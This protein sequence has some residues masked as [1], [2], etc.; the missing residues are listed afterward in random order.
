MP[1]AILEAS[2][3]SHQIASRWLWQDLSFSIAAGDRV[4][5]V[6][7]SGAGK[8]V[9]LRT[10]AALEPL[11]QGRICF[12]GRPLSDW[13][14]PHYRARVMYLA[15]RPSLPDSSV[16][17]AI[18][19]PFKLQ[20]HRHKSYNPSVLVNL[21]KD[22]ERDSSFLNQQTPYLSG[23]E[24]QIVT[25]LRALVL[26]PTILLLDEPTASLD[27]RTAGAIETAIATW[28]DSGDNRACLWTSHNPSQLKRVTTRHIRL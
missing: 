21:L 5:L 2:H 7:P 14:I 10:L 4:A 18:R 28:I 13:E 26:E 11:Q 12:G 20:V 1:P 6:G 9:L 23:G 17:D 3:L 16:E 27:E 8:T 24:R 25:F 19:A 22:L 15:Q